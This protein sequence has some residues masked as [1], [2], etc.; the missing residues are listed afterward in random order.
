MPL[1]GAVLRVVASVLRVVPWGTLC[2]L[3]GSVYQKTNAMSEI[4]KVG[5][6]SFW[7]KAEVSALRRD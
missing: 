4:K 3:Q 1:P 7:A 2:P 5:K 6:D